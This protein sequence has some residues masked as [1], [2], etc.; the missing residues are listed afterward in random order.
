MK[1][2]KKLISIIVLIIGLI[3]LVVGVVFLILHLNASPQMSDAE[4]LVKV[5]SWK[6][7]GEDC[8]QLK[9]AGEEKCLSADGEPA[10]SCTDNSS[11]IWTFTEVGKG[12][13]TTNNHQNDYEF[14]WAIEGDK[15]KIETSWLY[16]MDNEYT[17]KLDQGANTL[18]LDGDIV[19]VS[20]E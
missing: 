9:C 19:F 2:R 11:V 13:L 15:L 12:T 6:L 18:T 16:T 14:I 20:A 5:G 1:D 7:D 8:V 17:Y 4:H 3:V 10:E